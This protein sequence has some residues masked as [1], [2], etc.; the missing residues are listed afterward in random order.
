MSLAL[1]RVLV[2]APFGMSHPWI[3]DSGS[4]HITCDASFLMGARQNSDFPNIRTASGD[5]VVITQRGSITPWTPSSGL[6]L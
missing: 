2:P 4:Y 5:L 3:F 6:S 1:L